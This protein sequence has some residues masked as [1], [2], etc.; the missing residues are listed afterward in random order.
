VDFEQL[1]ASA[2]TGG[3]FGIAEMLV[4]AEAHGYDAWQ[5]SCAWEQLVAVPFPA[6]AELHGGRFLVL[7][8][9]AQDRVL[10][11]DPA[12]LAHTTVLGRDE[13]LARWS[14]R[15]VLLTTLGCVPGCPTSRAV[16]EGW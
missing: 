6:L 12:R 7:G 3:S 13:F 10:L 2:G 4:A 1:E 14:G 16:R 11:Q 15:L 8:A 9:F 5:Q